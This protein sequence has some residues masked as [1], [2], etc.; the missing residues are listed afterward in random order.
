[1][2]IVAVLM[3]MGLVFGQSVPPDSAW[4]K[5]HSQQPNG[6]QVKLVLAKTH[7]VQGERIDAM[8]YFSNSTEV[9]Y[10]VEAGAGEPGAI[11]HAHNANGQFLNDPLKW[12]YDWNGVTSMGI[13]AL[14]PIKNYTLQLTVN[15]RLNFDKPGIYTLYAEISLH[16]GTEFNSSPD[17][18]VV[19][20]KVEVTIDQLTPQKEQAIIA[21]ARQKIAMGGDAA[22]EAVVDLRCLRTQAAYAEMIPLLARA[23]LYHK[24]YWAFIAS[25]NPAELAADILARVKQGG[26]ILDEEGVD[27]YSRLKSSAI[28][29]GL[30]PQKLSEADISRISQE[31]R[32]KNNTA[33][34][35]ILAAQI[36]SAGNGKEAIEA[37]W[38]SFQDNAINKNPG[39]KDRDG[40]TA[41]AMMVTHQLELPQQHVNRL[42]DSWQYWGSADFLPLVRQQ[43]SPPICN[44]K[45]LAAL[46]Q[47]EPDE[48]MPLICKDVLS[49]DPKYF[50]DSDPVRW[51]KLPPEILPKLT[52]FLQNALQEKQI[53]LSRILD[54]AERYGTKSLVPNMA[55]LY[56]RTDWGQSRETYGIKYRVLRFW[57]HWEPEKGVQALA[58]ALP[59]HEYFD[60]YQSLVEVLIDNWM[61]EA[62][63]LVLKELQSANISV[64]NSA[65]FLLVN[66]AD[67]KYAEQVVTALERIAQSPKGEDIGYASWRRGEEAYRAKYVLGNKR[68]HFTEGQQKRLQVII[69]ASPKQN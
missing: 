38:V 62:I 16:H 67:E 60:G 59:K 21:Q 43:A 31:L 11:F 36:A 54:F 5:I 46:A 24:L 4:Q 13:V 48:A 57:I 68:W 19:S 41:R 61:P 17:I 29:F 22:N 15:E 64:V 44:P 42:L 40:G 12:F 18:A 33:R 34:A 69:T 58:E 25:P 6:V 23:P 65:A 56:Y 8:L 45:A 1:M 53:N 32:S 39:E 28:C 10:T 9:V 49:K 51:V 27:L 66:H 30:S 63:P 52:Q 50:V 37:M 7:F 55:A 47:L 3:N 20:Q 26:L 14:H 2:D 35:E